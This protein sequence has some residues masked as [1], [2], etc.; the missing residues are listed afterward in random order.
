MRHDLHPVGLTEE[1]A[2][3]VIRRCVAAVVPEIPPATV[4]PERTLA[5]LGCNSID[6]ADVVVMAMAELGVT[7]PV[8]EFGRDLDVGAIVALLRRHG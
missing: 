2:L 3:E 7:V 8:P 6:R 5:E 4:T 1:A